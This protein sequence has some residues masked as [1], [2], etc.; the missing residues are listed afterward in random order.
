MLRANLCGILVYENRAKQLGVSCQQP[1]Y[2]EISVGR[3]HFSVDTQRNRQWWKHEIW[4]IS[5]VSV[6]QATYYEG[7][8]LTWPRSESFLLSSQCKKTYEENTLTWSSWKNSVNDG[9]F[10]SSDEGQS[11]TWLSWMHFGN[12]RCFMSS[13]EERTTELTV[14]WMTWKL[15]S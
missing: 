7:H 6:K 2:A 10:K 8:C 4:M 11:R 5:V 1:K 15:Y 13:Y 9:C 12:H 14:T 3:I